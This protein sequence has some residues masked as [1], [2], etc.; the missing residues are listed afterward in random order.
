MKFD[1]DEKRDDDMDAG[2]LAAVY[3]VAG[4]VGGVI[5]TEYE[6]EGQYDNEWTSEHT[7]G[8]IKSLSQ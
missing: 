5:G 4:A 8:A 7:K 1:S 3:D 2:R 6:T